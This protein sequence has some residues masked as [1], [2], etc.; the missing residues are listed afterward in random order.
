MKKSYTQL[1]IIQA[2]FGIVA[3]LL[4]LP[5]TLEAFNMP[6]F[7][8][9]KF[10][11]KILKDNYFDILIYFGIFLILWFI[12]L[13]IGSILTHANLPKLILKFSVVSALIIPLFYVLALKYDWA[14]K[15]WIDNISQNIKEI[16][17]VFIGLSSG[18]FVL[19]LIYNLK[20]IHHANL[21]HI[22]QALTM[23]VLFILL[24][25]INGWCGKAYGFDSKIFGILIGLFAI[26][27]PISTIILFM[28]RNKRV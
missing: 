9:F 21:H 5:Y 11:P 14:L 24:V 18:S 13:N 4:Y 1:A 8:W 25:L 16:S 22:M 15:F 7:E 6:G 3:I 12:I 17:Y 23:C 19:G 26:Y 2:L 20:R 27:L 28:C 10:V